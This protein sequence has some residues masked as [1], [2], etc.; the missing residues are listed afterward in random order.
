[1]I[2]L[3]LALGIPSLAGGI[4]SAFAGHK[5]Y[6]V[7][8]PQDLYGTPDYSQYLSQALNDPAFIHALALLHSLRVVPVLR[9]AVAL[10]RNR[11]PLKP[12]PLFAVAHGFDQSCLSVF[13]HTRRSSV[14]PAHRCSRVR[15]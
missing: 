11:R 4:A 1:M 5:H 3:A 10:L 9:V 14:Q 13:I 2:P 15:L 12:L 8:L 7:N 6:N